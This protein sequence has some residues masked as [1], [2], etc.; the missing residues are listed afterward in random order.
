M[1]KRRVVK[2]VAGKKL[3][4]E[5]VPFIYLSFAA[6]SCHLMP[7]DRTQEDAVWGTG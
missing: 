7:A 3:D 2:E 5:E 1:N 6:N 4:G